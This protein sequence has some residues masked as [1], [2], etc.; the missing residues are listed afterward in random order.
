MLEWKSLRLLGEADNCCKHMGRLMGIPGAW[1]GVRHPGDLSGCHLSLNLLEDFGDCCESFPGVCSLPVKGLCPSEAPAVLWG[2]EWESRGCWR[3]F[4]MGTS[5]GMREEE[6]S[7]HG[8]AVIDCWAANSRK[9]T[10]FWF[11][12]TR[13]EYHLPC[14]FAKVMEEETQMC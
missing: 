1:G 9:T 3:L 13:I 4:V 7:S 5:P 12:I 6:S 11:L 2:W 14:I 10:L 8:A